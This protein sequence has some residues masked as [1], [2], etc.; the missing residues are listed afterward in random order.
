MRR[1]PLGNCSLMGSVFQK[2]WELHA[3]IPAISPAASVQEAGLVQPGFISSVSL[4]YLF[5]FNYFFNSFSECSL[6]LFFLVRDSRK[7]GA[8]GKYYQPSW[9]VYYMQEF[10]VRS[11]P[12]AVTTL[13]LYSHAAKAKK[14]L[15]S[16]HSPWGAQQPVLSLACLLPL[17]DLQSFAS[18]LPMSVLW[19]HQENTGKDLT[20]NCRRQC[21][22]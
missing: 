22:R 2:S 9:D 5:Y 7:A 17:C 4:H 19:G 10:H 15:F 1:R 20:P 6:R 8:E 14:R 13:H 11:S 21:N 3:A 18:G 12:M 16:G